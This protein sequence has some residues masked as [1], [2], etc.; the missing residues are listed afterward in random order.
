MSERSDIERPADAIE[1]GVPLHEAIRAALNACGLE[2]NR[3]RA[4]ECMQEELNAALDVLWR[5]GDD[6]ARLWVGLNYP[7]FHAQRANDNQ[8]TAL[9]QE[10][11]R[12]GIRRRA[13]LTGEDG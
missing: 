11:T 12:L 1:D 10:M 7:A 4:V 9:M 2:V 3:E 5:R 13:S 8:H 6:E